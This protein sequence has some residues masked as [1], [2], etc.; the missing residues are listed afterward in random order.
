MTLKEKWALTLAFALLG[1]C[2]F[3]VAN[4]QTS[5][6]VKISWVLPTTGTDGS[7]LVGAQALTSVQVFLSTTTIPATGTMVPT[8]TLPAGAATTTQTF[9]VAVGGTLYARVRACNV[10]GCSDLSTETSKTFPAVAP[11][12]PTNV[13]IDVTIT[14]LLSQPS[15]GAEQQWRVVSMPLQARPA[16]FSGPE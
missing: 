3:G 2:L 11:L 15:I 16:A 14:A 13:T 5:R 4:A 12:P 6:S 1:L 9:A 7:T 10:A 8:F